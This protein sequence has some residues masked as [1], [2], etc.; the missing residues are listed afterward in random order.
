MIKLLVDS[1]CDMPKEFKMGQDVDFLPLRIRIQDKEYLDKKE[2]AVEEVYKA[3]KEGIMPQTSQPTPIEIFTQLEQYGQNEDDVIYLSFSSKMSGTYQTVYL[4]MEEIKQRYPKSKFTAIDSKSGSI[5]IGFMVIEAN[6]MIEEGKTYEEI[7]ERLRFLSEH[8]EHIFTLSD[9][10][11]IV[12]GGRINK[13][14]GVLGNMLHIM[15]LIEV[16]DGFI[17]VFDKVRG[18]KKLLNKLVDVVEQRIGKYTNQKIG[19][20]HAEDKE[21]LEKIKVLLRERLG[22]VE[23][24]E[25]GI[26]SV[27]SAHLGLSGVGICFFNEI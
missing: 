5:C 14:E 22:D 3:M 25:T 16:N 20:V 26:G 21:L 8:A 13:F 27:L 1:T 11:W 12:K 15:P 2:I 24:I 23:F 9:L 6:K 10:K 18:E 7:V 19:L 17:E 4:A